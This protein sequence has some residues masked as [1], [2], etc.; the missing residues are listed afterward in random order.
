MLS[1]TCWNMSLCQNTK[2]HCGRKTYVRSTVSMIGF[3]I[4]AKWHFDIETG[5]MH[6]VIM[7]FYGTYFVS[8]KLLTHWGRVTPICVSKLII[9]GSDNGLSPGRRQAIIWTSAGIL[10]IGP[11]GTNFIEILIEI[12]ISLFK[13]THLKMSSA[14]CRASC[15]GLNVLSRTSPG[16]PL[17]QGTPFCIHV[18][19]CGR[20]NSLMNGHLPQWGWMVDLAR[21]RC[22]V[23]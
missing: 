14:K 20:H 17:Q 7:P 10:L 4:L 2:S 13:K 8:S 21:V 9:I 19:T 18:K 3:S 16:G 1:Y 23:G 6:Y 11:M 5:P 15:P 12:Y 22:S